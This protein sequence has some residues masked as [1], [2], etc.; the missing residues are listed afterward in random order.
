MASAALAE[1]VEFG[2]SNAM[3][4]LLVIRH[5]SIVTEAHYAPFQAGQ[6]HLVNSV[7]KSVIGTLVGIALKEGTLATLDQPVIEFFPGRAIANLDPNKKAMTLRS[8]LDLTSGLD[9][10]E[11]LSTA[12]P[13]TMLQMERSPEWVGFV[14]DRPM[15]QAP[16]LAFN[17]NSGSWHLLSAI[18]AKQS[19]SDTLIYAGDK[20]F[21]PLG[22]SDVAWRRDPQEIPIGGYGLYML[23]RDM[24]KLGYLY[25]QRGEW[26]GQRLLPSA[27]IDAIFQAQVDMRVGGGLRYANGW[28]A[29]PDRRVYLAVGYLSQ[30][31]V[32]LPDLDIVAVVTGRQYYP[33]R[34]VIDRIVGAVKSTHA[35]P[36]DAE[37][38][39]RLA[40]RIRNAAIEIPSPV[41]PVSPLAKIISGKTYRFDPN[42]LGL[43][44][45]RFDLAPV[46]PRY[47][48]VFQPHRPG[49]P[50]TRIRGSIGLDG[51]FRLSDADNAAI[52]AMKGS[53]IS[54]DR[55]LVHSRFVPEGLT[56][57]V[58]LT[59]RERE[60]DLEFVDSRGQRGRMR[61]EA[62]D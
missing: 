2:A 60:V 62:I 29:I 13:E 9:W 6:K 4:S 16:G 27:W 49:A 14:L 19:A 8:L 7:T 37:G 15:A 12:V 10:Q 34:Q 32:V 25:L 58:T 21:T 20:L 23:P 41:G 61:G 38:N 33:L 46:N 17:Y 5:G 51:Y 30:L 40:D 24:A 52:L 3:D 56:S 35:I 55:F 47:E 59:F 28:W 44:S 11:P 54:A 57:I 18:L 45:Q 36:A 48:L 50:P 53:W 1:L 43:E 26:A 42:P 31:I 39:A 22:I